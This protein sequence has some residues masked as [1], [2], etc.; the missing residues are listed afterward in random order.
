[1]SIENF[2]M[3]FLV[4]HFEKAWGCFSG[5]GVVGSTLCI[6]YRIKF[7]MGVGLVG[8]GD[9]VCGILFKPR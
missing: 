4:L 5:D 2:A 8:N 1:M 6:L 7:E 3:K 9:C